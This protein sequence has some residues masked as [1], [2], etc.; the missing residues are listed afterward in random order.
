MQALFDGV[1]GEPA[2]PEVATVMFCYEFKTTPERIR[3]EWS[4][5]EFRVALD[6]LQ[7]KFDKEND[8]VQTARD[9]AERQRR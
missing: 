7:L 8:E 2:P 4:A 5:Y 6:Y 3:N 1:A 9:N